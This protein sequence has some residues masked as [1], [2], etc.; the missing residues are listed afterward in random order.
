MRPGLFCLRPLLVGDGWG[1]G[2]LR[3]IFA[4]G[5]TRFL[6]RLARPSV[7]GPSLILHFLPTG[8]R[9]PYSSYF[10]SMDRMYVTA[11]GT[12]VGSSTSS[13]PSNTIDIQPLKPTSR[14]IGMMRS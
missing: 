10:A 13:W 14:I 3:A 6:E 1:E 7:E 8:R 12:A 9:E 4:S 2:G 11:I 5:C